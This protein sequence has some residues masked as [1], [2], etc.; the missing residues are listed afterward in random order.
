VVY[1]MNSPLP[2]QRL[3]MIVLVE[4]LPTGVANQRR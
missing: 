4:M 2:L 1:D 3:M